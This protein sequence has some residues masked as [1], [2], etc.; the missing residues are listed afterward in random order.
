MA[1]LP[2]SVE[3]REGRPH[4]PLEPA[5]CGFGTSEGMDS[6]SL[7]ESA[8]K[9]GGPREETISL[10]P[11]GWICMPLACQPATWSLDAWWEVGLGMMQPERDL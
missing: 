11:K 7:H 3:K 2:L 4:R 9:C 8:E 10:D 5:T 6:L 1:F